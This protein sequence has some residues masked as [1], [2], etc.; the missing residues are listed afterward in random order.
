MLLL[1]VAD[2]EEKW[3]LVLCRAGGRR[4]IFIMSDGICGIDKVTA[5]R[6]VEEGAVFRGGAGPSCSLFPYQIMK[7]S[8]LRGFAEPGVPPNLHEE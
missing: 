4:R 7:K 6:G 2:H 3:G 8:G 1:P 5:F